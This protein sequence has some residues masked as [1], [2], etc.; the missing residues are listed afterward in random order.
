MCNGVAE[1]KIETMDFGEITYVR[2]ENGA[3]QC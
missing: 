2:R 1:Q 3:T